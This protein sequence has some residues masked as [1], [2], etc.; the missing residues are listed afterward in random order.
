MT[1]ET[2]QSASKRA[3]AHQPIRPVVPPLT[4]RD[5]LKIPVALLCLLALGLPAIAIALLPLGLSIAFSAYTDSPFEYTPSETW[6][7]RGLVL[8]LLTHVAYLTCRLASWLER[9]VCEELFPRWVIAPLSMLACLAGLLMIER[10]ALHFVNQHAGTLEIIE[11]TLLSTNTHCTYVTRRRDLGR[12]ERRCSME[13][14]FQT[15]GG[16]IFVRG[17][18]M[19]R[20]IRALKS[21]DAAQ[22]VVCKTLLGISVVSVDPGASGGRFMSPDTP[23]FL[24]WRPSIPRRTAP[25]ERNFLIAPTV[26]DGRS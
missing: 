26:M 15:A 16:R 12:G 6:L 20:S 4:K 8:L 21:G 3:R 1:K 23:S 13:A 25:C 18:W 9:R 11:S 19:D 7:W 17:P 14:L 2:S 22:L 10:D 5:L 24:R